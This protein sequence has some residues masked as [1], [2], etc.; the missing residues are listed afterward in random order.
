MRISAHIL[1]G[2]V[3]FFP[4]ASAVGASLSAKGASKT[5]ERFLERWVFLGKVEGK[6]EKPRAFRMD[7]AEGC[8]DVAQALRRMAADELT[9]VYEREAQ[10]ALTDEAAR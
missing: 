5:Q 4:C 3:K 10:G 9:G 7:W 2:D 8:T 6:S 1:R